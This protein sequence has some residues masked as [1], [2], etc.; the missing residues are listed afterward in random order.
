MASA[1]KFL[2]DSFEAQTN[3]LAV[4]AASCMNYNL[5]QGA[6]WDLTKIKGT[7]IVKDKAGKTA[8]WF[9]LC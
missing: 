7:T 5:E 2:E 4:T 9:Q 3:M 6:F 1:H 8:F